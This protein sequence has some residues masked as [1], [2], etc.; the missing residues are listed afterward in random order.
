MMKKWTLFLSLYF[1]LCLLTACGAAPQ[2]QESPFSDGT[3]PA[4]TSANSQE[5]P[6]APGRARP[7]PPTHKP[8]QIF[9]LRLHRTGR[10]VS[11]F[12]FP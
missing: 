5:D 6:P 2:P 12:H 11:G 10:S 9:R 3:A 1:C 4:V 7:P 8:S